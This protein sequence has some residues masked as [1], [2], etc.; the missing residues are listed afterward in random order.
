MAAT[1]TSWKPG[2]SGNPGGRPAGV[3]RRLKV[4]NDLTTDEV[5]ARVWNSLLEAAVG[6]DVAAARVV[7]DRILGPTANLAEIDGEASDLLS[8]LIAK[9]QA[10]EHPND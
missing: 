3:A 9:V 5:L 10:D 4:L 6:G 1:K 8:L 7:L 2:Q